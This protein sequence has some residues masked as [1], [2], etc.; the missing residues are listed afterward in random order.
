MT[1]ISRSD[2]S[3]PDGSHVRNSPGASPLFLREDEIRRGVELL[4]FGYTRLTDS[5]D[6]VLATQGLGRAHHRALYFIA[7]Q[8]ELTVGE[9]LR[10]LAI[11]KQSLGRVL[12]DLQ[13]RGLLVTKTG[14]VDR[15]QKLLRLTEQGAALE[16]E[17][18]DQLREKLSA[19]YVSAG[20]ESV[21][22]FWR[23]L[24]G[25]VPETDRSM[26]FD[27]RKDDK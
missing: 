21:T 16:A 9:L 18:F 10:L 19:A 20:Q 24:E 13:K 7:R 27:L 1:D 17:L 5:I 12:K 6:Q 26:V 3:S 2:I 8:P 22:G 25:L 4:Y 11:T 14:A 15:R 23:V